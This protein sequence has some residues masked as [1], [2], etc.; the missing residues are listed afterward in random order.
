ML[1]VLQRHI[2]CIS[3]SHDS[4]RGCESS[5]N[6]KAKEKAKALIENLTEFFFLSV[7]SY[8]LIIGS[9]VLPQVLKGLPS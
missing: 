4:R 2:H 9:W 3:Q 8:I 5:P 6:S 7:V 1:E